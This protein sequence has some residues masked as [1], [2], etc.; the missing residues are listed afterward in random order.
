MT[1]SFERGYPPFDHYDN[2]NYSHYSL[3][4]NFYRHMLQT[5]YNK[6]VIYMMLVILHP[7]QTSYICHPVSNIDLSGVWLPALTKV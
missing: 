3:Q 7:N 5:K 1:N 2:C 6:N 4:L